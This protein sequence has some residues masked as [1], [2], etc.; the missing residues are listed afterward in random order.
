MDDTIIALPAAEGMFRVGVFVASEWKGGSGRLE[1]E[2]TRA[3]IPGRGGP[4][5]HFENFG[6]DI[7]PI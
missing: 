1:M 5:S 4:G 7:S 3:K 6:L 2:A